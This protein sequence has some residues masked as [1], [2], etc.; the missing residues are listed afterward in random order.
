MG[1]KMKKWLTNSQF[2]LQEAG[3]LRQTPLTRLQA[4]VGE[5]AQRQNAADSGT[6]S[7]YSLRHRRNL[8]S[9]SKVY[10]AAPISLFWVTNR[11]NELPVVRFKFP[12][13]LIGK[14]TMAFLKGQSTRIS[15]LFR[16]RT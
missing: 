16:T 2:E 6:A 15:A 4:L 7:P 14:S 9:V 11:L 1:L 8:T 12:F 5:H 10:E 13:I 3:A